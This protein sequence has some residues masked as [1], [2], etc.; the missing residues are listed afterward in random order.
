MKLFLKCREAACLCDKYQYKE[1][2]ISDKLKLK[3]HLLLCKLCNKYAK[4]NQKLTN[5]LKA[6]EI[7]TLNP[8]SKLQ[9][10]E[11]LQKELADKLNT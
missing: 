6:V 1:I 2:S 3:L 8:D 10:K 4:K 11:K 5:T 7:K 9:L